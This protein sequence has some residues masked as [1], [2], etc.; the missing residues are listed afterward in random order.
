M[1]NRGRGQK[2]SL[3]QARLLEPVRTEAGRDHEDVRDAGDRF[4]GSCERKPWDF[5]F[6]PPPLG[7][8]DLATR[9][10]PRF[11]GGGSP[12]PLVSSASV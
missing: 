9:A 7:P 10:L 1:F 3:P 4:A 12:R 5:P 2:S 6:A 11:F 8:E